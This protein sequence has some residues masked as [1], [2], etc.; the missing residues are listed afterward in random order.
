[1]ASRCERAWIPAP[2]IAS[3]FA[4]SRASSRVATPETA[5]E[6]GSVRR[7]ADHVRVAHRLLDGGDLLE[8]RQLA[9]RAAVDDDPFEVVHCAHGIEMRA[10]LD[11]RPD[12]RE[13]LR[14]L[15]R[16]QPRRNARDRR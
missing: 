15:T 2:M 10:R 4:P 6:L 11:S 9:R 1:M 13:R 12:D 3:V 16:E 8:L 5:A 14:A 7:R